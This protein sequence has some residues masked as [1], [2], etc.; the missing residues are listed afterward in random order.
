MRIIKDLFRGMQRENRKGDAAVSPSKLK[1]VR[2]LSGSYLQPFSVGVAD[3]SA[4]AVH[5][6][7]L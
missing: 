6:C 7:D 1:N 2:L 3:I 5:E 4:A